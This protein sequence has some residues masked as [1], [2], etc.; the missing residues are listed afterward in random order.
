MTK[1]DYYEVLGLSRE[2][3]AEELKKAYRRLAREYHPDV[4]QDDPEAAEK[5]KE[6]K[7]AFDVL[8][9]QDRRAQYDRFGHAPEG[10]FAGNGFGGFSGFGGFED[11]LET[12]F[13]GGTRTG[14]PSGPQRGSDLRYDLEISLQD[15]A[16]G[17]ETTVFVPRDETCETCLGSGARP[18]TAPV[19]CATCG[20]SGQQQV[21]RNTAFGRFVSAKPCEICQGEGRLIK[22]RCSVCQGRGRLQRERKIDIKVPP[23][24]DTG[25]RLRVSGEGEAGFRGGPPGDLYIF[26]K[27]RPHELFKREANDIIVDVPVSF[28]QAALGVEMEVPTLD[29][30]ARLKIPEGTQ[31]GTFFRLRGKGLPHLRGYGRGDQHVHVTVKIPRKLS[32][33]EKELLREYA[34]LAGEEVNPADKG[35]LDK[36]KDALGG[37]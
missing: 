9:D 13:G 22:E 20:G 31:P 21:V 1:R 32:A 35:I 19:T 4:N 16:F 27:V 8:S 18:G 2:A 15:V 12:F 10:G 17:L 29:G 36:V 11:I 28:A 37:K 3:T 24:V 14:R 5:F 26:F 25:S 7:E 33:K 34:R 6:I 23:G 30:K